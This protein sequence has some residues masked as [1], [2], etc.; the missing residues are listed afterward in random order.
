VPQT[1]FGYLAAAL[2]RRR[3]TGAGRLTLVSRDNLSANG[4]LLMP[5]VDRV[6]ADEQTVCQAN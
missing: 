4:T 6:Q 2:D 3:S 1:I 5:P